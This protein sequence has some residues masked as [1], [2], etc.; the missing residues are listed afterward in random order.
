MHPKRP[1]V[2]TVDEYLVMFPTSTRKVLDELRKLIKKTAPKTEEVI[3]YA[4][5]AYK[6]NKFPVIYFAAY[7]NH[8]GLYPLPH[9]I[10]EKFAA[11]IE[12]YIK[13]KGTLRFTLDKP[14][15]LNLIKKVVAHR[16]K[17]AQK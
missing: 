15:P 3:S 13:G 17:E 10:D 8:I 5:P 7:E 9:H 2:A 1:K 14:L 6:F 11:E 12:P 4:I 16:Y